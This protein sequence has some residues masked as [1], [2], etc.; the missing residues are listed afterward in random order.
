MSDSST[1]MIM[2][3]TSSEYERI[4]IFAATFYKHLEK[5]AWGDID[6]YLFEEIATNPADTLNGD[7]KSLFDALHATFKEIESNDINH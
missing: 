2:G 1:A 7:C 5:D 3:M 4:K 6:P